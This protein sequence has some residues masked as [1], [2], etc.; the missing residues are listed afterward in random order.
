MFCLIG[1]TKYCNE[2]CSFVEK[3]PL[4]T[5]Q[6]HYLKELENRKWKTVF[7]LMVKNNFL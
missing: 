5:T 7:A 6:A 1:K 4:F 3:S 2:K